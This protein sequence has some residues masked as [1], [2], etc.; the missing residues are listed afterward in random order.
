M[1]PSNKQ[2]SQHGQFRQYLPDLSTPRFTAIAQND[3]YGHAKELKERQAPPW[4][5]GLY[6]H[7]RNL[8]QEPFKGITN[9]G[10]PFLSTDDLSHLNMS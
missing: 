5:H 2:D 9:D 8:L 7:W 10:M 4:L 1:A 3:A 6:I